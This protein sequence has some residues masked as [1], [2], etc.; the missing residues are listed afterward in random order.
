MVKIN[1]CTIKNI[2]RYLNNKK[3]KNPIILLEREFF[4]ETLY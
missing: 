2:L 3:E 4:L 1:Y